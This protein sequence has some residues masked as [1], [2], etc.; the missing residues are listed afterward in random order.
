MS[1]KKLKNVPSTP[2]ENGIGVTRKVLISLQEAPNFAMRTF[3]I[4]PGGNMPNHTNLVEHEQ[5]VLRGHARIGIGAESYDV[6]PGDIVYIPANV[7]HYYTNTG[8]DPFEFICCVPNKEDV[9][10]LVVGGC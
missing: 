8:D 9:T 7:P 2:V 4:Q 10:T 3:T 1:V 6:E 5:F